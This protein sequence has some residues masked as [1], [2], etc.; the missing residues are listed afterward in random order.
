MDEFD[1]M[2]WFEGDPERPPIGQL[3]DP[4]QELDYLHAIMHANYGFC[5]GIGIFNEDDEMRNEY[6]NSVL[7]KAVQQ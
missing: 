3:L 1:F 5:I 2:Q 7:A 6:C 4:S